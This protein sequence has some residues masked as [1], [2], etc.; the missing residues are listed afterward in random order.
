MSNITIE[1]YIHILWIFFFSFRD[2]KYFWVPVLGPHL[3][4]II[5]AFV[6]QI[7]VGCHWPESYEVTSDIQ[8]E[9]I[10]GHSHKGK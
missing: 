7:C 1:N 9:E 5:G 4:A 8:I 6:Y 10:N 2:Y 3:G